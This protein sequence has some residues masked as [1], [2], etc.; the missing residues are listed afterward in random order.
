M[1]NSIFPYF[2]PA[3]ILFILIEAF[4]SSRNHEHLYFWKDTLSSICIGAIAVLVDILTK[5]GIFAFFYFFYESFENIRIRHLG[6]ESLGWAWWVWLLVIIGDDFSFYWHHRF[7]HTIRILWAAHV[8]HHSSR[9]FN[10]GTAFR[11]SWSIFFYKPVFWIWLP[12]IGF[13]PAMVLMAISINSLYQFWL[14]TLKISELGWFEKVF[15]SPRLHQLHHACN[16]ELLDKN[17]GGILILWDRIFGTYYPPTAIKPKF[18]ITTPLRSYN[19]LI[20]FSNEYLNIWKDIKKVRS[21]KDK[22]K[23]IFY[24][25]GWSHD[26]SSITVKKMQKKLK[27]K[28]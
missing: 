23:Y 1:N 10:L 22:L 27:L 21:W 26:N 18:G 17:H 2:V 14:H 25:P 16:I 7:S 6:Y 11:N 3:G 8:M 28:L 15:N 9:Y 5:A 12:A 4:I 20:A 13:H 24:P 19:P